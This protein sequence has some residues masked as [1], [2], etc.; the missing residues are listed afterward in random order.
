M[1][2]STFGPIQQTGYL[3]DDLE[4]AIDHWITRLGVGPWTVFRNVSLDGVYNGQLTTV[5]MHVG[6]GYHGDMQIELI[7]PTNA[8]PSPYR[9]SDGAVL[10]GI[11]HIA[12]F[13]DDLDAAQADLTARGLEACFAASNESTRVAYFTAHD[14]PGTLYELIESE[15]TKDMFAQGIVAARDWDG[16][17][18][19]TVY[20]FAAA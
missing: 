5:T 7:E 6:L 12:A 15:T 1:T 20:D 2:R 4:Q 14:S 16:S 17:D 19:I 3:V 18:P 11:H 13:T 10:L 9:G 8:A